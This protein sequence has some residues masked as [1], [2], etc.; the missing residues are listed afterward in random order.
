MDI[1][2]QTLSNF[3]QRQTA[4]N[5]Y[6]HT[7]IY[8]YCIREIKMRIAIAKD[9]FNRMISLLTCKLNIELRKRV[10]RYYVWNIALYGSGT[11]IVI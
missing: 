5:N 2:L 8:G 1:M 6:K 11:W 4:I 7:L 9:A 3:K 10:V